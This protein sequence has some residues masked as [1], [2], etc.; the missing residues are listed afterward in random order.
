MEDLEE[1][2]TSIEEINISSYID[3]LSYQNYIFLQDYMNYYIDKFKTK[4]KIL[5]NQNL[6][7]PSNNSPP[8]NKVIENDFRIELVKFL[9]SKEIN[10]DT[11]IGNWF[12]DCAFFIEKDGKKFVLQIDNKGVVIKKK[13]HYKE[14][15]GEDKEANLHFG[16]AQSNLK[17]FQSKFKKNICEYNGLLPMDTD[18]P[19]LT[20]FVKHVWTYDED[21]NEYIIKEFVLYSIPHY[22]NQDKYPDIQCELTKKRTAKSNK[23]F[24]FNLNDNNNI[25][26]K[27][28]NYEDT[29]RYIVFPINEL[30]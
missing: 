11:Y 13:D 10:F 8:I 16:I 21:K 9:V 22:C 19:H 25:P 2:N 1:L 29:N 4:K 26:Y 30:T 15:M 5:I 7:S 3:D 23:E 18:I 17:G 12:S 6:S 24:R 28:I 14:F 20:Y 27:F